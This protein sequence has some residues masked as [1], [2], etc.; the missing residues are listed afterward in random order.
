[1][2]IN[3][4]REFDRLGADR[5]YGLEKIHERRRNP[6]HVSALTKMSASQT[7]GPYPLPASVNSG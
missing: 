4:T 7:R 5:I 3:V 2:R 6:N 1:M